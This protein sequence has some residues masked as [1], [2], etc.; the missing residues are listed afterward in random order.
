MEQLLISLLAHG[1]SI[2][3]STDNPSCFCSRKR[4]IGQIALFHDAQTQ[5][6]V[7]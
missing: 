4:K 7:S 2:E 6:S 5:K 3:A 1:I